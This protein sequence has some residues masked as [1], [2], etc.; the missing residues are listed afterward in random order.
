MSPK[1]TKWWAKAP[2]G[3]PTGATRAPKGAPRGANGRQREPKVSPKSIKMHPKV[4]IRKKSKKR[5]QMHLFFGAI[6][7]PFLIKNRCENWSPKN[8]KQIKKTK[9]ILESVP[10]TMIFRICSAKRVSLKSCFYNGKT[11]FFRYPR[12]QKLTYFRKRFM[13]KVREKLVRKR[14]RAE[15]KICPKLIPKSTKKR[16]K[17]RQQNDSQKGRKKVKKRSGKVIPFWRKVGG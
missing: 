14:M 8:L 2:Q 11:K 9:A 15:R 7:N 5:K 6:L 12:V 17:K 1:G 13:Q 10:K 4:G 3:I 16:S